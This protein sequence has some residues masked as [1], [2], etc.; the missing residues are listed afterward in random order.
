MLGLKLIHVSKRCPR[1]VCQWSS[2]FLHSS[3]VSCHG[4]SWRH[5]HSAQETD[6]ERQVT[7]RTKGKS[8]KNGIHWQWC[9][10]SVRSQATWLF[11][12][13]LRLTA[14][15]TSKLCITGP[16]WGE[17]PVTSGSP[18]KG[19][20][21]WEAFPCH[22]IIMHAWSSADCSPWNKLSLR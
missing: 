20:V 1:C 18:H 6:T 7:G 11:N 22:D 4:I 5:A 16:L 14:K 9:H 21:M 2:W 10:M 17:S 15:K 12:S 19:P 13:L 8:R 3:C